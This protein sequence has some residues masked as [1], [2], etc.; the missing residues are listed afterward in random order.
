MTDTALLA[1]WVPQA[2]HLFWVIVWAAL[3]VVLTVALFT[4][5]LTRKGRSNPLRICVVL[6]LLVHALLAGYATTIE[7]VAA[8]FQGED[9]AIEIVVVAKSP[10]G[11][12]VSDEEPQPWDQ[13]STEAIE[14]EISHVDRVAM[15]AFDVPSPAPL[16]E[17]PQAPL[18][19][20][21]VEVEPSTTGASDAVNEALAATDADTP[22]PEQIDAPAA[23]AG[24][25]V[26]VVRP[27]VAELDRVETQEAEVKPG[28]PSEQPASP[29][30]EA[31]SIL[32]KLAEV[33]EAD[34]PESAVSS[35]DD[36]LARAVAAAPAPLVALDASLPTAS[37]EETSD[38]AEAESS[39][40]PAPAAVHDLPAPYRLRTDPN[41]GELAERHGGGPE[42]QSAVDAALAWLASAQ[43]E[44][45]RWDVDHWAGGR[46]GRI[47]GTD[48]H[49]AGARADTGV[50]GLTILAFLGAGHTHQQG[51][52][53]R[54]VANALTYLMRQQRSDGNLAGDARLY[55]RMY[56][57]G[58]AA[59]A[60]SEAYAMT[61]DERLL[62]AAQRAIDYVVAAQDRRGGGW[63]YRPGD[64]GDTSQLGWQ[65]MALKSAELA[66]IEIPS[67]TLTGIERFLRSVST[68][69]HGGLAS[70]Q[71][72]RPAS[73][74]MTAE[75]LVCR[76]FLG[77]STNHR[78][79]DEA[80]DYLVQRLPSSGRLNLY[81]CY[82][83]T[84][85]LH[86]LQ[87]DRW[88]RWNSALQRSL[89]ESQ[90]TGGSSL[91]GPVAGSW[92]PDTVWGGHGG[93][94]YT[95]AMATL[96]LE[97]YY[98]YAPTGESSPR[99]AWRR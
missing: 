68:G 15:S 34:T 53:Q 96:C 79:A 45:G 17:K 14:P 37:G 40:A 22:E 54:T 80:A 27:E 25:A 48:R 51:D 88:S 31:S 39:P 44:D 5:L 64:K 87:D 49:G 71:P 69:R 12:D 97:V 82:Y 52:Y 9:E 83:A 33:R 99:A 93:R 43:S 62:P 35:A 56:C 92:D 73:A 72:G 4:L 38:T 8:T 50:T 18:E 36:I 61:G 86:P 63:R 11:T 90:R 1:T 42:A 76:Q 28:L 78:A 13:T 21:P 65:V 3:I 59:F 77:Q 60:L 2:V 70:Y 7:I 10:Q 95:T 84:L 55:A 57:H 91:R 47:D 19:L 26:E 58:M 94:A 24:E 16:L 6:S 46:E 30:L 23:A 41:R 32:P 81:Y 20:L 75:A 67:T 85:A 74:A 98:R 66:G 89:I 29:L